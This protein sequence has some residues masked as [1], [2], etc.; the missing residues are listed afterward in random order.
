M[1]TNE[2]KLR[3]A[4]NLYFKNA[5]LYSNKKAQNKF[6]K[7]KTEFLNFLERDEQLCLK[8]QKGSKVIS[9]KIVEKDNQI[10]IKTSYRK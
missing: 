4:K 1:G 7:S 6:K 8:T 3:K 10:I 5:T 2:E 9:D